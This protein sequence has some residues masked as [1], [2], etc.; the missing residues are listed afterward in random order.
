MMLEQ[1]SENSIFFI[2]LGFVSISIIV[3]FILCF[4][5]LHN[6]NTNLKVQTEKEK[7]EVSSQSN[8]NPKE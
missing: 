6:Y 1:L 8:F 4:S 7:I 3:A 2:S 5:I